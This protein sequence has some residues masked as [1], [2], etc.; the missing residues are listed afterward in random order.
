VFALPPNT[1]LTLKAVTPP[2]FT[3]TFR[4]WHRYRVADG[5]ERLV[6]RAETI[7]EGE[8][9]GNPT[10]YAPVAAATLASASAPASAADAVGSGEQEAGTPVLQY[11]IVSSGHP[12]AGEGACSAARLCAG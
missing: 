1:L 11:R 3:A 2:P 8:H 9:Q 4:R 7:K 10:L 5:T 12:R 6:D